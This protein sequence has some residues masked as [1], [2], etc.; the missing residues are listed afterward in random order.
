MLGWMEES[1]WQVLKGITSD[2][3]CLTLQTARVRCTLHVKYVHLKNNVSQLL[4]RNGNS[5]VMDSHIF[6]FLLKINT[7]LHTVKHWI[8]PNLSVVAVTFS[9]EHY[10]E[11]TKII[12]NF[13]NRI[14][15]HQ[16]KRGTDIPTYLMEF[17]YIEDPGTETSCCK[18][19]CIN[20]IWV[21]IWI[22][23]VLF[24]DDFQTILMNVLLTTVD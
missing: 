21:E 10:T 4:H 13:N 14:F 2:K 24:L 12:N 3:L 11:L 16:G 17:Y 8:L 22:F 20:I 7:H 5:K 1:C 19:F 18:G 23:Q 9:L 15:P 6:Y